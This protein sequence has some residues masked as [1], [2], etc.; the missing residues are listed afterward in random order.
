MSCNN[1]NQGTVKGNKLFYQGKWRKMQIVKGWKFIWFLKKR[2]GV[3]E[4]NKTEFESIF[5]NY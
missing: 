2:I 3:S 1:I 4:I 5:C